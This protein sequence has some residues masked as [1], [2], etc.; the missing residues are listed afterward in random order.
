MR[1]FRIGDLDDR[2]RKVAGDEAEE[3][4]EDHLGDP[5]LAASLFDLADVAP[6]TVGRLYGR[7]RRVF[8]QSG[9]RPVQAKSQLLIASRG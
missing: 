6:W 9:L 3:N 7:R 4:G 1:D 8:P 5:P 2:D